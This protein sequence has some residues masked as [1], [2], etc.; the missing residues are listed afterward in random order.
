MTK[1]NCK[2]IIKTMVDQFEVD[3]NLNNELREL[4]WNDD[5]KCSPSTTVKFLTKELPSI[6]NLKFKRIFMNGVLRSQANRSKCI[7]ALK[8][9]NIESHLD[10]T[11]NKATTEYK[12][13]KE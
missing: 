3:W 11:D 1:K 7:D 5:L 9:I 4:I 12:S 13:D 8:N 2:L 10:I 6:Y